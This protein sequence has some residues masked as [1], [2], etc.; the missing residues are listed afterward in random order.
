MKSNSEQTTDITGGLGRLRS[1][2]CEN[3]LDIRANIRGASA[4]ADGHKVSG[5]NDVMSLCI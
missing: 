5:R 2:I 4:E 3:S 1:L